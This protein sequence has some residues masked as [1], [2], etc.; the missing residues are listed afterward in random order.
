MVLD[1]ESQELVNGIE[2]W[3]VVRRNHDSRAARGFL[4]IP[5]DLIFQPG[6]DRRSWNRC[7]VNE[8]GRVEIT[9][10]E[11]L[12]D[13]LEVTPDL[14]AAVGVFYVVRADV[15]CAAVV[16]KL[17][18]MGGLLVGETHNVVPVFV[19]LRLMIWEKARAA[20]KN[21]TAIDRS[22]EL[23]S[24]SGTD[25]RVQYTLVPRSGVCSV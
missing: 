12:R 18:M 11:H 19:D 10:R 13:V 24:C 9:N 2:G 21:S 1:L 3:L 20:P 25:G 17:K 23:I 22:I 16:M 5:V 8:H 6:H 14:V 15:N 7:S 4:Q